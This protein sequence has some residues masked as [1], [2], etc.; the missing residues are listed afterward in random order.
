[1]KIT[2]ELQEA[3]GGEM[4]VYIAF[5]HD[6]SGHPETCRNQNSS[7]ALFAAFGDG[8]VNTFRIKENTVGFCTEVNNIVGN[9]FKNRDGDRW[10]RLRPGVMEHCC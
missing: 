3:I 4:K 9:I 2:A 10:N 6:R 1:V 5:Q 8:S 7:A